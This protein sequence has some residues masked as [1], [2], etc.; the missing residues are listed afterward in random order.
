L[1]EEQKTLYALFAD[2]SFYQKSPEEKAKA[3]A[4]SEE[5]SSEL[6]KANLRWEYLENLSD[7]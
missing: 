6:D 1:E 7:L 4:R 5:L 3:E 2:F